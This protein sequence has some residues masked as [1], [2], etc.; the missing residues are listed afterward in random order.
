MPEGIPE[1]FTKLSA[2]HNT[3]RPQMFRRRDLWTN[4]VFWSGMLLRNSTRAADLRHQDFQLY[5]ATKLHS[6][7]LSKFLSFLHLEMKKKER[8][9][10]IMIIIAILSWLDWP[11]KK[12]NSVLSETIANQS[13]STDI[14]RRLFVKKKGNLRCLVY[15][16]MLQLRALLLTSL[17]VYPLHSQWPLRHV[18]YLFKPFLY[19]FRR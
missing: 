14:R 2:V 7:R 11:R 6:I 12:S 5:Q 13:W 17:Y 15:L 8:K 16:S 18:W 1:Y 9:E 3:L 4:S 10:K 19:N